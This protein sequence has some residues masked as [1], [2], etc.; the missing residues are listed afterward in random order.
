M[1]YFGHVKPEANSAT[2]GLAKSVTR[3]QNDQASW[4]EEP[5]SCIF[6]NIVILEQYI[7]V[8]EMKINIF[9][10]KKKKPTF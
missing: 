5:L 3:N 6:F 7:I 8:F 2:H 10:K 9:S 4:L 1:V